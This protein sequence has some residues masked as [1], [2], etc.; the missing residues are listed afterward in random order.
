MKKTM[1]ILGILLVLVLMAAPLKIVGYAAPYDDGFDA[2]YGAGYDTGYW[3]ALCGDYYM[4]YDDSVTGTS[5]YRNGYREGYALGYDEGWNVGM[6]E[7]S[8]EE[9]E[10]EDEPGDG[11][12]S[13][14]AISVNSEQ[15]VSV[16]NEQ[17]IVINNGQMAP[18][19]SESGCGCGQAYEGWEDEDQE[20]AFAGEDQD[21]G[22]AISYALA[23]WMAIFGFL[24]E[25]ASR[26]IQVTVGL[27]TLDIHLDNSF[28]WDIT[29]NMNLTISGGLC[30][31]L[32]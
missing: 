21:L 3:D 22:E 9:P 6:E 15:P 16:N 10:T 20:D 4:S 28:S 1:K 25:Y 18:A 26:C 13:T 17:T 32:R 5:Q 19:G 31:G 29:E 12:G 24:L 27:F 14:Y 2:G 30:F 8:M 23:P 11:Y 7:L